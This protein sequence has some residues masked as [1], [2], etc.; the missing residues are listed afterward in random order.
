MRKSVKVSLRIGCGDTS[1]IASR[2]GLTWLSKQIDVEYHCS[3]YMPPAAL[4]DKK[5][6]SA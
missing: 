2:V 5:H 6:G 4:E 3:F 1:C